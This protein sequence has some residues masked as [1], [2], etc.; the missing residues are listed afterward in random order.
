MR[1]RGSHPGPYRLAPSRARGAGNGTTADVWR[2]EA[3]DGDLRCLFDI[4]GLDPRLGEDVLAWLSV[5]DAH[6]DAWHGLTLTERIEGLAAMATGVCGWAI[7][8]AQD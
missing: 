5:M 4:E 1:R 8:L 3:W 7:A 6:G 2:T